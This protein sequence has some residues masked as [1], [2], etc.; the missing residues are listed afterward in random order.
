MSQ[1]PTQPQI[2]FDPYQ[3]A[4]IDHTEGAILVL[5]PVGTGKTTVLTERLVNAIGRGIDP[6][7]VLSVTFTNRAANEMQGR[8]RQR[9]P[10][11]YKQVTIKTFHG[12]C[13]YIL[14]IESANIGLPAD[15]TIYDEADCIALV[16]ETFSIRDPKKAKNAYHKLQ[17]CKANVSQR[18]LRSST[19]T[20]D[21]YQLLDCGNLEG[22]I[23]YQAALQS[24]HAL[25]FSDL[26][27]YVRAMLYQWP[28]ICDR[29][30][31]RFDFVQVDEVQDTHLSEYEIIR[32]L[33][34]RSGNLA[35][36]GDMDQ[37]IYG[38]RGSEPQLVLQQ[39]RDDFNP[40]PYELVYNY[41]ATRA[42]LTAASRFADCF[43]T[44]FTNVQPAESC[45]PGEPVKIQICPN[46]ITESFWV[47]QQIRALSDETPDFT[48]SR[49]AILVRCHQ[50][51]NMVAR[52]LHQQRIPCITVE[53][54]EFFKRQEIKDALAFLQFIANPHDLVAFKRIINRF[55]RG[56]G[57]R[58]INQ[59]IDEGKLCGLRLTDFAQAQSFAHDDPL[60]DVIQA[61]RTGTLIVFDV[62]TTGVSIENDVIEIA[63]TK[64]VCGKP[65]E[66][67]HRFIAD[68]EP[69]GESVQIHGYTNKFLAQH[70]E[71]ATAVFEAFRNF[72]GDALVVGHNVGFDIKMVTAH[73]QRSGI[74]MP[75]LRWADTWDLAKRF[76]NQEKFSLEH[77]A[78]ALDLA[79]TPSHQATDDVAATVE[80][81]GRLIP[82]M[83]AQSEYRQALVGRYGEL[84]L[85]LA[86]R[87]A[88]WTW[89][90][91]EERPAALLTY[92]LQDSGLNEHYE[93]DQGRTQNLITL[94]NL[95]SDKDDSDL[96]PYSA[97]RL[98]LEFT[99]LA[100]NVDQISQQDNQVPIITVHQSK[101]LEFD[102]I[103]IVGMN[104]NEFPT[105][106]SIRDDDIEEEKRLFYVVL[107]R[108]KMRLFVSCFSRDSNGRDL[109]PSRFLDHLPQYFRG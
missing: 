54:Y 98:L 74:F 82:M 21:L 23:A 66:Q 18:K 27:Y 97:L 11:I 81:L 64:L 30:Q 89:L 6:H 7:R 90:S 100:K 39:F 52:I 10:D 51:A 2:N 26:I 5:A 31:N 42:L 17:D 14:R 53:Q 50:R 71:S 28:D 86:E 67:F 106:F 40:E 57:R 73:A 60:G 58:G 13:A 35:M 93:S 108:A 91:Y 32:Y 65:V 22:A 46:E 68:T 107:T 84:F 83:E 37:S 63:A 43:E 77:L 80:L 79:A 61:H 25:D 41:R 29:W 62:E 15:F 70:G 101:G 12:L 36:I 96:H 85:E 88:N 1:L 56:V 55:V 44:R 94:L 19:T 3:Q 78:Q 99:A 48:Y 75:S 109:D 59:I 104:E 8:V 45:Q 95:F 33:S 69:V 72:V 24:A 16:Q 102:N 92:I 38:W 34:G 4:I 105:F 76:L 9:Y 47:A 87:M 49:T 20:E 103:F